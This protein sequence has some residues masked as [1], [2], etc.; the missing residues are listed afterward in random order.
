[1]EETVA[2]EGTC[3]AIVGPEAGTDPADIV[4]GWEVVATFLKL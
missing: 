4:P 1:V 3:L 2:V